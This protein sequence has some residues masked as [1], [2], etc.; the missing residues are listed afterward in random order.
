MS[1][2]LA[3]SLPHFKKNKATASRVPQTRTYGTSNTGA[4]RIHSDKLKNTTYRLME[5][6]QS[7]L[8]ESV[9]NLYMTSNSHTGE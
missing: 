8:N 7:W 5:W 3:P 4:L 6:I 2:S 1:D 9:L